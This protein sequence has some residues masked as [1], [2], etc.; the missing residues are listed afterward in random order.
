[1]SVRGRPGLTLFSIQLSICLSGS[2]SLSC[3][4][5]TINSPMMCH[6][7]R[8]IESTTRSMS[9]RGERVSVW[10]FANTKNIQSCRICSDL[11]CATRG[12]PSLVEDVESASIRKAF[13]ESS[14]VFP[15]AAGR[16]LFGDP[17]WAWLHHI[18]RGVPSPTALLLSFSLPANPETKPKFCLYGYNYNRSST[19]CNL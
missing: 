6:T 17:F 18:S 15:H 10:C 19:I 3:C 1:M 8:L 7:E 11:F 4:G 2:A 9:S 12:G 14:P 13:A 16:A 5:K